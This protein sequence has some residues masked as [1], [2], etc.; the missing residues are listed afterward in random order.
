V[1]R[2]SS[3]LLCSNSSSIS[4][5]AATSKQVAVKAGKV[6]Q[7]HKLSNQVLQAVDIPCLT[8][9]CTCLLLWISPVI[10]AQLFYISCQPPT[11]LADSEGSPFRELGL[12]EVNEG[13]SNERS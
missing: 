10:F 12:A 7:Q 13:V 8:P 6:A 5:D 4:S 9:C 1:P 3:R 2:G 11:N